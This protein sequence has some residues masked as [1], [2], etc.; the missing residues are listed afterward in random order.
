[1]KYWFLTVFAV[2]IMN[3]NAQTTRDT[4][5]DGVTYNYVEQMPSTDYT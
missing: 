1:M 4:V 2:G 3:V 5:I